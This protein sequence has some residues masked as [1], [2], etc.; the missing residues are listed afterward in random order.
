MYKIAKEQL[1]SLFAAIAGKMDLYMPL[2]KCGQV[3]Y[4]IWS[5]EA[6]FSLDAVNTV[7]SPKDFFFPQSETLYTCYMEGK[8][9]SITPEEL[10]NR[11]F[12]VFGIRG[13]DVKGIQVLDKVFLA[14]PVDSYYKARRDHGVLISM[15]CHEP[16]VTCFC[17]AFGVEAQSPAGDIVT[18]M[19]GENLYWEPKTEKGERLTEELKSLLAAAGET[20]EKAVE[21]EKAAIEAVIEKLPYSNISLE[22][23]KNAELLDLFNSPKWDE[24][25]KT[26]LGCGTCTFI[27]PTCQCYDIKDYNTGKGVQRFRCW[28]SCMY[29]DFTLMA[30]GNIRKTQKERF[31]QR[32]MHKLVYFP[33]NNDG[34]F[35]CVGC[36]RCVNKCPANLN[37]LKVIKSL[38]VS[39]NV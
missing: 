1:P 3:N 13:C 7:K 5:E 21:D 34:M 38:G 33:E 4:G 17:K 20:D 30:H 29:S 12:A 14:D 31:R 23:F 25:Y 36:G 9:I 37:I 15:A 2:K 16:D 6:E 22:S 8:K 35:S 27:C 24:L 32:F 39:E 26:C 18:W 28:D 19:T 10:R 11:P